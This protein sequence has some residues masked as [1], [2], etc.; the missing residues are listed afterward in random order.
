MST[1]PDPVPPPPAL[2]AT[3]WSVLDRALV[4]AGRPPAEALRGTVAFAREVE[5]LG[6]H[7][8]WVA[9]HHAV[10]GVAGAA[11]T[12]L[13]A[14]VASATSRIRVGT[15]GVMLPNHPPLVVAEQFGV[16]AS[17]FPDRVDMGLG[18]SVGFTGAVR[19]ALGTEREA[20]DD[21]AAQL[22]ELLSYFD[23]TGPVRA[24]PARGLDV[25]AFVLAGRTGAD[26]AADLGLPLVLASSADRERTRQTAARYRERFTPRA[27]GGRPRLL[28]AVNV[29]VAATEEE[30]RRRQLPEAWAVVHSRTRGDFPPL[31]PPPEVA[32]RRLTER[33]ERY[34]GEALAGQVSGTEATVAA[35]LADLVAA[36]GAEEVMVTFA[37]HDPS[38]QLDSYRRL[39]RAV[40]VGG[41]AA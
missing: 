33:E 9:E 38:E 2:A 37:T 23:G 30:A 35:R 41:A 20:M 6:Y 13:A 22:G 11:P 34:L 24:V 4:R 29:A 7:R 28:L 21:F 27:A 10:P 16:L 17:L 32:G 40:G 39:A 19:R 14:A 3:R 36:T 5:R 15:G 31:P 1:P 8:F 26:T 12:V 25:P 18:R